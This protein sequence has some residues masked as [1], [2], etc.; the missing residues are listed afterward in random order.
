MLS[1][2]KFFARIFSGGSEWPMWRKIVWLAL[3][4]ATISLFCALV[5]IEYDGLQKIA[6]IVASVIFAI[7]AFFIAYGCSGAYY[8]KWV[9]HREGKPSNEQPLIVI[10]FFTIAVLLVTFLLGWGLDRQN[11]IQAPLYHPEINNQNLNPLICVN[12]TPTQGFAAP[13][14]EKLEVTGE[15]RSIEI[16]PAPFS[17]VLHVEGMRFRGETIYSYTPR[18]DFDPPLRLEPGGELEVIVIGKELAVYRQTNSPTYVIR[19]R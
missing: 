13:L 3:S 14:P 4:S 17:Y 7:A 9:G 10:V 6:V 8:Q 18:F 11:L 19:G 15:I 2:R 12:D 16:C 1:T 5:A